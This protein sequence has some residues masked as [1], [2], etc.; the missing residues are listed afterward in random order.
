MAAQLKCISDEELLRAAM[1]LAA[2]KITLGDAPLSQSVNDTQNLIE[3]ELSHRG[4][5]NLETPAALARE[6]TGY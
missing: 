1:V 4:Y 6:I 2:L 3:A 5:P